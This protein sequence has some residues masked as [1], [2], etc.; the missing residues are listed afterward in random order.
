ML[1]AEWV[2]TYLNVYVG[3]FKVS[4]PVSL[5]GFKDNLKAVW[6]LIRKHVEMGDPEPPGM[7]LG[8]RTLRVCLVGRSLIAICPTGIR[9]K[10]AT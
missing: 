9:P 6:A 7:F 4:A 2:L 5:P 1:L 8:C 10:V 3:D